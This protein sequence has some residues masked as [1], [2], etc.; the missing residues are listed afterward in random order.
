MGAVNG[1]LA[2]RLDDG[3]SVLVLGS[4]LDDADEETC[5][6]LLA[7][8]DPSRENV[9]SITFTQSPDDRLDAWRSHNGPGL[10]SKL[11]I[12]SVG[13]AT[14]SVAGTASA[15]PRTVSP[16][17]SIA[18][19]PDPSN[20]TGLGITVSE[21]LSKWADN[22]NRTVVC[23]H[24]LSALLQ[25]APMERAFRFL[26]VL[27]GRVSAAGGI[28]HFH[29]DPQAH[30]ESVVD[31]LVPLFDAIVEVEDGDRTFRSR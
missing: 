25:F 5:H 29:M 27:T 17:V 26:H 16:G 21:Y 8:D 15:T 1:S 24:S 18:T 13:D 4:P 14:R 12:V 31:T 2:S 19:V 23:F 30:D 6:D 7:P 20:L 3:T 11:G 9:L 28:A 10:P 22:G